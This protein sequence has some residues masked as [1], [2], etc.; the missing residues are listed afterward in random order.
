M[1]NPEAVMVVVV[2]MVVAVV[3]MVV[4]LL[5]VNHALHIA[6]LLHMAW[7]GDG[8]FLL[9]PILLFCLLQQLHEERMIEVN[10]RDDEPLLLLPLS[11]QHCK[12]ALRD[13]PPLLLA[14]PMV[15]KHV[16]IEK[17]LLSAPHISILGETHD[18]PRKPQKE[19]RP[20]LQEIDVTRKREK[21][22]RDQKRRWRAWI[23][24]EKSLLK[25]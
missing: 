8:S 16:E 22:A 25:T 2:A 20:L 4:G 17:I 23:G 7:D 6:K 9:K 19:N 18:K 11:H 14:A 13:V 3:A 10:D 21:M 12:T 15:N 24:L 5:L 1:S